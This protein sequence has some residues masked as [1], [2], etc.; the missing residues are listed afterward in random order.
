MGLQLRQSLSSWL[1]RYDLSTCFPELFRCL[2]I[3]SWMGV[4][5][6][7]LFNY[8]GQYACFFVMI[9][10]LIRHISSHSLCCCLGGCDVVE[11]RNRAKKQVKTQDNA[12]VL[13]GKHMLAPKMQMDHKQSSKTQ[14]DHG[15]S[16][17]DKRIFLCG[18]P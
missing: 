10:F 12:A 17:Q 2:I 9:G 13:T 8:A 16:L 14:I 3:G 15:K 4:L 7:S 6:L 18:T 11:R 5:V 1:C